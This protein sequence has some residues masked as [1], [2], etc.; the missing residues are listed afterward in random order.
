MVRQFIVWLHRWVGLA[1]TGFLIIVSLTGSLLAFNVELERLFAPQLFAT[2]QPDKRPLDLATLA[3]R[4][5]D[6]VPS[7]RVGSVLYA[8]PDQVLVTFLTQAV[9][10]GAPPSY[11]GNMQLFL[12]P[13]TGKELGR[14]NRGDISEGMINFM[15]FVYKLHWT[16]TFGALGST[17]L[18]IIAIAW[19]VDCFIGFYLT[20]P[21][22]FSG[23]FRRWRSAWT[24]K[25]GASFYRLNFDLHRASGLWLWPLL[26]IFAWSSV[27]FNYRLVYEWVTQ[28]V[29]D[30]RSP[31]AELMT[32]GRHTNQSPHLDW[33]AAQMIGE[34]LI[35]EQALQRDFK[36]EHALGLSYSPMAGIYVYE[37]RSSR[38]VFER[39]PKGGSTQIM[40]DGDDGS[41]VRLRLPTGEHTG[42]TAESWLYALHLARVF[43]M[44]YR[45]LVCILG[46]VVTA[47]SGTGVY[48]WWKKRAARR[49]RDHRAMKANGSSQVDF[50]AISL[51]KERE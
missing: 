50:E 29:F 9:A 27:M 28:A 24:L 25:R 18:G 10:T 40:F 42:N 2:L 20:L 31:K 47:L 7:G 4:A 33:P 48:I 14:R 34:K 13:W 30:Y 45:I 36:V 46:L 15:P 39:S 6:L 44:P 16:L 26:F 51:S 21:V 19:S 43:G 35:N 1:M 17:V 12:D 23:F 49:A 8:E 38:D 41:F 37:V 3:G 11:F 32:L 5:Q 22:S